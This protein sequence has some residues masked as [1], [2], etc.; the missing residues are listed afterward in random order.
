M[1]RERSWSSAELSIVLVLYS[2][3][4]SMPL[5][6]VLWFLFLNKLLSQKKKPARALLYFFFCFFF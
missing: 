1:G 6:R 2:Q 4:R 5:C 3:E